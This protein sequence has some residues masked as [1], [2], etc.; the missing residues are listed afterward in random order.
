[1]ANDFLRITDQA[2]ARHGSLGTYIRV[3][4]GVYNIETA[5]QTNTTTEYS[6]QMY[7]KHIKANQYNYPALIGKDIALFYISANALEFTPKIRDKIS[8]ECYLG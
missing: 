8:R 1:M 3:S 6:I 4:A 5:T 7:K 2:L